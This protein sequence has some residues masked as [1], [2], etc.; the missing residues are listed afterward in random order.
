MSRGKDIVVII[1][2]L[3]GISVKYDLDGLQILLGHTIIDTS[4]SLSERI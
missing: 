2:T 4:R 1:G 3:K